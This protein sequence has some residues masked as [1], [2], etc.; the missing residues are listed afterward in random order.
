MITLQS[1]Q[2]LNSGYTLRASESTPVGTPVGTVVATDSDGG[3]NGTVRTL[4]I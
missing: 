1:F 2:C 4:L 3:I